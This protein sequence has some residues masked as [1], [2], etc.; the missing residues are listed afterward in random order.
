MSPLFSSVDMFYM[1]VLFQVDLGD[2]LLPCFNSK[3]GVPYSDVNLKSGKPHAPRWGPDSST[4]EVTTIQL[5]FND[6]SHA[7][8]NEKYKV[9]HQRVIAGWLRDCKP[10]LLLLLLFF[11]SLIIYLIPKII[12]VILLENCHSDPSRVQRNVACFYI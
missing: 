5:E 3:S 2:R 11:Y 12:I 9:I 1:R 6:L 7:S 8:G 4:S 10:L